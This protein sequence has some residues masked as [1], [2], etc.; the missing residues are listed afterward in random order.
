MN[1]PTS[2]IALENNGVMSSKWIFLFAT[3]TISKATNVFDL[4]EYYKLPP[5]YTEEDYNRCLFETKNESVYCSAV[6]VIKPDNSSPVWKLI[7]EYSS[8]R[9][10]HFRHDIF[11]NGICVNWCRQK[12]EKHDGDTNDLYERAFEVDHEYYNQ[13]FANQSFNAMRYKYDDLINKCVNLYLKTKYGLRGYSTVVSCSSNRENDDIDVKLF[14]MNTAFFALLSVIV[15]VVMTG[16]YYHYVCQILA[17]REMLM[18]IFS[19]Q[20][21]YRRLVSVP[22]NKLGRE[23]RYLQAIRYI[24]MFVIIFGHLTYLFTRVPIA[25]TQYYEQKYYTILG[26]L[27]LNGS[28]VVQT[29]FLISGL[30]MGL[31]FKDIITKDK[32]SFSYS[33]TPV[34]AIVLF[35]ETTSVLRPSSR[36]PFWEGRVAIEREQCQQNWWLNVLYINNIFNIPFTCMPH[37]WFLASDFQAFIYGLVFIMLAWRYRD[38]KRLILSIGGVLIILMPAAVTYA[39]GYTAIYMASPEDYKYHLLQDAFQHYYVPFY[40]NAGN[41]Y[42]AMLVG[43]HYDLLKSPV[44]IKWLK[45]PAMFIFYFLFPLGSIPFFSC[46]IFY[47][48]DIDETAWWIGAWTTVAKHFW[49]ILAFSVVFVFANNFDKNNFFSIFLRKILHSPIWQ[50]LVF[51]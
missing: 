12:L 36:H 7:E 43:L 23:L 47:N 34:Y 29:F 49:G 22:T 27:Q 10:K 2:K 25:N 26:M 17:I 38:L 45:T 37:T 3:L 6:T 46:Y 14:F 5:L 51:I 30:L 28:H 1:V 11:Y 50:P 31:A 44:V 21:N 16:T 4:V 41:Y 32:F 39:R 42:L 15:A 48:Y 40:T 18:E 20:R 9:I 35:Y 8:D 33:L 19:L 13:I 24:F